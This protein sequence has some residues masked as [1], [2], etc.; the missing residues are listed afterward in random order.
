MY[1]ALANA[2]PITTDLVAV[3]VFLSRH[4]AD[5]HPTIEFDIYP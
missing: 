3:V 5:D 1:P 2:L 4:D